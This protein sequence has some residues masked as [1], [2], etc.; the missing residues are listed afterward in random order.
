MMLCPEKEVLKVDPEKMTLI[1]RWM[2]LKRIDENEYKYEVHRT[3]F[4]KI[5]NEVS[6]PELVTNSEQTVDFESDEICIDHE[7][8]LTKLVT[9][10]ALKEMEGD[11]PDL[12]QI[13]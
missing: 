1:E 13:L 11:V 6:N 10:C 4:L 3:C 5:E 2:E 8:L 7:F 12:F 9:E